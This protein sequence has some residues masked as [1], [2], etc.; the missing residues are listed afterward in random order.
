MDEVAGLGTFLEMER[1]V[2]DNASGE[3]VQAELAAFV[4]SLGIEAE[5][6]EE[7]YDSLVRAALASA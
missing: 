6:T 5:R 4:A 3:A 7:T 2:P 1:I